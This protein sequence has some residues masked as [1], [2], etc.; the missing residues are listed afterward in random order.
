MNVFILRCA[1]FV[2]ILQENEVAQNYGDLRWPDQKIRVIRNTVCRPA[3]A[4]SPSSKRAPVLG[5]VYGCYVVL[6]HTREHP[7]GGCRGN[8][9]AAAGVSLWV[10]TACWCSRID[11]AIGC[12][13][14]AG[15]PTGCRRAWPLSPHAT[16]VYVAELQFAFAGFAHMLS[17]HIK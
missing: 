5:V 13:G 10:A 8:R 16:A 11:V 3:G 2:S 14:R 4:P 9:A 6:P 7:R 15:A 17:R 1:I 12:S